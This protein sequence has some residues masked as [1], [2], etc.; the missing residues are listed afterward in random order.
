MNCP[1]IRQERFVLDRVDDASRA[2]SVLISCRYWKLA[3]RQPAGQRS[4]R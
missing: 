4:L 1:I 2:R 3:I